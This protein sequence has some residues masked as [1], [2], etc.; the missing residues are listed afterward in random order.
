MTEYPMKNC[1][2]L[3]QTV[4]VIVSHP[5]TAQP[6][7]F[8]AKPLQAKSFQPEPTSMLVEYC[9]ILVRWRR[10]LLAAAAG[11][12]VLGFALTIPTQPLY[13]TRTSL[14]VKSL[15][16]DY[17]DMRSVTTTSLP[18]A[19]DANVSVLQTDMKLLQSKSM[20]DRA[21]RRVIHQMPAQTVP[22]SDWISRLERRLG[23]GAAAA[24]PFAEL[25]WQTAR[26][27]KVKPLGMTSL[28]EITCQS[29]SPVV[30]AAFCNALTSEFIKSD[31]E[32]RSE[33]ARKTS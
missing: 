31:L 2:N 33:S 17:L 20:I 8:Q 21:M 19:G 14:E 9:R 13:Q 4:P 26:L 29:P 6:R 30:A 32:E 22:P 1:G 15:N 28:L 23:V 12:A 18:S 25:V 3:V 11:G 16:E 5:E 27:T 24:E 7:S 10:W